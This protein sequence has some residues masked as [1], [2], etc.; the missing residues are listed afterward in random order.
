MS[1]WLFN[2]KW[3]IFELY[4]KNSHFDGM[5]MSSVYRPTHYSASLLKQQYADVAPPGHI[6]LSS[7]RPIFAF[8]PLSFVHEQIQIL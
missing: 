8:T 4:Q 7:G 5:M 1:E 2:A 6:I 3:V